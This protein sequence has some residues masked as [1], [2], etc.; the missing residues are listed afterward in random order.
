VRVRH[1]AV[2]KSAL[3]L[4]PEIRIDESGRR[5]EVEWYMRSLF[6]AVRPVWFHRDPGGALKL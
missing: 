5:T 1:W 3:G 2:V 6:E 4:E